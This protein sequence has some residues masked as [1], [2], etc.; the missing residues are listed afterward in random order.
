MAT[1]LTPLQKPAPNALPMH[2]PKARPKNP[3][4]STASRDFG[5][6]LLSLFW[7]F[8]EA[9]QAWWAVCP[10]GD[11]ARLNPTLDTKKGPVRTRLKKKR[12]VIVVETLS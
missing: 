2:K 9:R 3:I 7:E 4:Y 8:R 10:K 6:Q 5:P 1:T 11:P 12:V